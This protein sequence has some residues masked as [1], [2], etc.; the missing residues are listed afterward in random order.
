M[1]SILQRLGQMAMILSCLSFVLFGLL[2]AMPGD[3]V[4]MLITSNPR[5]KP[6]DVI[7]LKKLRGLDKPWYQ[8]Y[9][10]W[11]WGYQD[12]KRPPMFAGQKLLPIEL[13]EEGGARVSFDVAQALSD[14]GETLEYDEFLAHIGQWDSAAV[15]QIEMQMAGK[16]ISNNELVTKAAE[17]LAQI[18]PAGYQEVRRK[19]H[20]RT[21]G[22][23]QLEGLFGAQVAGTQVEQ[24]VT[25]PGV[26]PIWFLVRDRD[27]LET[28]GRVLAAVAPRLNSEPDVNKRGA[29]QDE[30]LKDNSDGK[31]AKEQPESKSQLETQ[32]VAS[33]DE[34]RARA[35]TIDMGI[36][37]ASIPSQVVDAPEKFAVSLSEYVFG[38]D[39]N[40]RGK[41]R[42]ALLNDSPGAIDESGVYRHI[43]DDPGQTVIRFAVKVDDQ[44]KA[45]GAFAVEHGPIAN[46]DAFHRG[47][48]FALI[49]DREALGFSNTY[50][51]PVWDILAGEEVVCGDSTV[52]PGETCDDGNFITGDGCSTD[53]HLESL[54][55]LQK[56]DATMAGKLLRSGR[57]LNTLF[58][59]L[60]AILLSLLIAIPIGV[61]SAY[62][63][64]SI[65]DYVA[66]FFAFLGISLPVFWFGI[67]MLALFSEQLQ[68]LPA[69]G[70]QTPGVQGG[71]FAVLMDRMKYAFLPASVLSIAY[72]G[73][74]LRYMRA[75]ML[76]VL[77]LDFVRTA[78]AKGLRESVVV[79]KHAMRNA[80][81]PVVT[82]LAL[83]VPTLFGGALLTETVFS[84]PGIGR[85]QFDAVMSNDYY[86]AIVVFLISALL[87]MLGNLLA[88]LLYVIVDPRIRK[89]G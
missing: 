81:I 46:E 82:V 16:Q 3:P 2:S 43:F 80:L 64:Y 41:L 62:R 52:G 59:M 6:E 88:D 36:Q 66:N 60:P 34:L 13:P 20:S 19:I 29:S 33:A 47:F 77:P 24:N 76:E 78:R 1:K 48:L 65:I 50:K 61:I 73:R 23:L 32:A 89:G 31:T 17:A 25:A 35:K 42:Y 67:M 37:I 7:R 87:V 56:L 40:T 83:S 39:A 21:V 74:W 9:F 22:A 8:Q 68:I 26:H 72:T 14:D 11:I 84:W 4:D 70:M 30:P 75:S 71:F 54:T 51:R 27:G 15:S 38:G 69:G 28:V 86:V 12:P 58:L 55:F 79:L 5:V 53:C 45:R 63:Q 57:V 44:V 18:N 85:L 49:G 10:R